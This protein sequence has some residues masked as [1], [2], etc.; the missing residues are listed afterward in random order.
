M[1]THG[2]GLVADDV[3]SVP[4]PYVVGFE[5][6]VVVPPVE[7]DFPSHKSPVRLR[8]IYPGGDGRWIGS[9]N[10]ASNPDMG[11]MPQTSTSFFNSV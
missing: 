5:A 8:W 1:R 7:P 9:E 11:V 6:P 3:E 2:V 10:D 4:V